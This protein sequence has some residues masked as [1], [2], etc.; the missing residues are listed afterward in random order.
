MYFSINNLKHTIE[1]YNEKMKK[2]ENFTLRKASDSDLPD[3]MST[4][5]EYVALVFAV[6]F[7]FVELL[8]LFYCLQIAFSCTQKG[9]E[10]IIHIVLALTFT[11]PYALIN[12]VFNKCAINT[13]RSTSNILPNMGS[14]Y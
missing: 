9:P 3:S 8:V 1:K 12:V 11:M 13:L 10:R 2:K 14:C 6:I 7:F 5:T 4:F